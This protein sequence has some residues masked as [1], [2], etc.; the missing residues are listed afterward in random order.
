MSTAKIAL[1]NRTQASNA[2]ELYLPI[3]T[4]LKNAADHQTD[5]LC[6]LAMSQGLT[7]KGLAI[8]VW[9]L[10]LNRGP[11]KVGDLAEALDCDTG[12]TSGLIDRLE[13]M[14]VVERLQSGDD[15]RIRLVQLT[16][17]GRK[18]G[19]QMERDYRASWVY[20]ELNALSPRERATFENVLDRLNYAATRR[21]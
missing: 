10:H 2:A 11:M 7:S 13:G 14:S 9:W 15:R 6:S 12:N 5:L 16:A 3:V 4:A 20:R 8:A 19:E 17:K 1:E 18:L 21:A